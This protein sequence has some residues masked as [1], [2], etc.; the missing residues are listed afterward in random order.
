MEH[1]NNRSSAMTPETLAVV[2]SAVA[3]AVGEIMKGL[4]PT[5][6][7]MA[8]TPEKIAALREPPVDPKAR[9]RL[10]REE[11]ENLNSKEQEAETQA[12]IKFQKDHCTHKDKNEKDSICL[13]RNYH[14]RQP[15]GVCML[16][17]DLIHP[18]EWRIGAPDDRGKTQ[19]TIVPA[20]KDYDRVL[21][22]NSM[23]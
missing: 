22:I 9:A 3:S 1:D 11:R 19:A 18:R 10:L 20:H 12:I 7:A 21:R 5:F 14:D 23:Q 2:N 4:L 17:N 16:C 15:R 13:I 8:L 6:Q